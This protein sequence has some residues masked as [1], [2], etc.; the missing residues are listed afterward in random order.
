MAIDLTD[1]DRKAREAVKAFWGNREKARKKQAEAGTVDQG[2]RAGVTAGKNMDGF[3]ALVIDL[4]QA[5]GL[6]HA[7]IHRRRAL[8]TL[9][10]YFRPT[11]L[12]DLL[13]L[14]EGRLIAA[15]E[16]KSQVG[17]S[18]GNNFNNRTEEAVGTS[19]DVWTAYR[20]GAFGKHPRPFVAWLMLVEDAPRSRA[21]V[22]DRSPHFPVFPEF[23]GASYLKRYDLLCQRL[24]QEQLY[25]TAAVI[26]SPRTAVTSSEYNELSEMTSLKTFVT[27]FAGHIAAEAARE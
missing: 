22:R 24:V 16:L 25:T 6:T 8:L 18:F 13:V 14:N 5:N 9:P 23:Q 11:K 4:V 7:A 15:I 12:W 27:S 17:P 1:Y 19:H 21:P 2:E 26:T 10:G 3:I 20:E